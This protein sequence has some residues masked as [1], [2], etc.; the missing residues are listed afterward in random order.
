MGRDADVLDEFGLIRRFFRRPTQATGAGVLLGIGDDCALLAPSCDGQALAVSSD[1]LVEGR[2]FFAGT[3]PA[4]VGHKALAVNLSDLAAMGAEP[5]GFT[6]AIALPTV[7]GAWLEAFCGGLFALADRFACPLVGGD[8]TRGPL[9]LAI[10]V[11][12]RVPPA[13][14]LRRDLARDGHDLWVSGP[15]GGAALA[16][17]A[18]ARGQPVGDEDAARRL[19]RPEPRVDLGLAL[20]GHAHAAIDL[21]DGL[22]GDLRHVIAA[23]S[24]AIGGELA[25]ELHAEAIPLAPALAGLPPAAALEHAISGGDDYELLFTAPPGER[26]RIATLC[27]TGA[28]VGRIRAA[29]EG[30]GRGILLVGRDGARTPLDR[31]GFD[32]FAR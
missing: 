28:V 13:Q 12:G 17:A 1:M 15:L 19:D 26:A 24:E 25:A 2:H 29:P 10:T 30:G 16:V 18:R 3:D 27:P 20:R 23:S 31:A 21:S 9:A 6:L 7:D 11:F 8:T 4:A 14:A 22:A 32:H 5:V